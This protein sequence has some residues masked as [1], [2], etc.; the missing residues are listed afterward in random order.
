M[1]FMS[2]TAA[3]IG[4]RAL[5]D[6]VSDQ[7]AIDMGSASTIIW[8]SGQGVVVDEPSLVLVNSSSGEIIGVGTEAEQML[9]RE[10][11]DV[12][13]I[14]P[15]IN[16]VVGDFE[17]TREMLTRLVAKARREGSYFSRRAVISVLSGMTEVEQRA[18]LNVAQHSKIGRVWMVEEGLAAALGAGIKVTDSRASAIVDVGAG[19]TNVAI[20]TGGAIIHSAA[21]RIGSSAINAALANHIR[22]HR[23]LSIG[24]R[25]SERLKL[26]LASATPPE[27]LATEMLIKGHDVQTGK[28]DAITITAGE[29]YPVVQFVIGK[30]LNLV[31]QTLPELS[32]EVAGDIFE[33]GIILTGGGA[34]LRGL[35]ENLRDRVGVPVQTAYEPKYATV[36]GLAQMFDQPLTMRHLARVPNKL[37][38]TGS[39]SF[40]R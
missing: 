13:V 26:Q 35:D 12:R 8:L 1:S 21:E 6:V 11:R 28:P 37:V 17:R 14:A 2:K 19:A 9:G 40:Q 31:S 30:I 22:R 38:W 33:R 20:V 32:P 3:F 4:L 16:G 25:T 39:E 15:M 10:A 34:Q 7:I 24:P 36:R 27:D 18:L 5:R 23:G 29:I